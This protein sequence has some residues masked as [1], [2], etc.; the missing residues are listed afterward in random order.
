M[1][2]WERN[3]LSDGNISF[4]FLPLG[5]KIGADRICI[6]GCNT[7]THLS[8][9]GNFKSGPEFISI[10]LIFHQRNKNLLREEYYHFAEFTSCL[11]DT[12]YT[13][14]RFF[15]IVHDIRQ[16]QKLHH[17]EE[18]V[19]V[20]GEAPL[21]DIKR[22]QRGVELNHQGLHSRVHDCSVLTVQVINKQQYRVHRHY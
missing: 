19:Q 2:P 10:S 20:D 14:G 4:V 18:N 8:H 13:S 5:Q 1:L 16:T 9:S 7:D 17:C 11:H 3:R 22:G 15:L 6:C 12:N 21:V